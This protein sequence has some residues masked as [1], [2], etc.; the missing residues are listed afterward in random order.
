MV[1]REE[2]PLQFWTEDVRR[3]VMHLPVQATMLS[4][5]QDIGECAGGIADPVRARAA[6]LLC[7]IYVR[8]EVIGLAEDNSCPFPLSQTHLGQALGTSAVH[9][10]RTLKKLRS[11][12]LVE[13]KKGR[14]HILDWDG[15]SDAAEFD[16]A[17]LNLREPLDLE[18]TSRAPR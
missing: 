4:I 5:G 8:L 1:L 18:T 2:E 17:Y 6:H 16:P 15:L 10:N 14:L 3:R 11:D 12:G 13:I 7:E 9:I